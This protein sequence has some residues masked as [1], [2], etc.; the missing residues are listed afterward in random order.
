[1]ASEQRTDNEPSNQLLASR[2]QRRD[3]DRI[4]ADMVAQYSMNRLPVDVD[5]RR[6]VPMH[7]GI[8]RATHLL[9]P[10]PA[11]LLVNIPYFFLNCDAFCEGATSVADPFCGSGTV[12]LEGMI[13]GKLAYGTDANPLARLIA[14]AK[15]TPISE[16]SIRKALTF[17]RVSFPIQE[18]SVSITALD[19]NHWYAPHI[20]ADLSRLRRTVDELRPTSLRTFFLACL[21]VL[22]RK[23]SYAD[24]RLSVPVRLSVDRY[25]KGHPL[26]ESA[27][28]RVDW[29]KKASVLEEFELIVT[30]NAKRI[31][32]LSPFNRVASAQVIGEDAR[33]IDS[34]LMT[35]GAHNSKVDLI[36]SSPP[37][38]GAQKYIRASSL[39]LCWLGLCKDELRPLERKNIGRE[40]YAKSE[41][42][43]PL[44]CSVESAAGLLDRIRDINPLRAHI[45]TQYLNEMKMAIRSAHAALRAGGKFVLVIGNNT[46]CGM[47]FDTKRYIHELCKA[48]GF[49]TDFVLCDVIKSRGL[50]TKRNKTASIITVEWILVLRK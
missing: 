44:R 26:H 5:F 33:A 49:T 36:I 32:T 6:I 48:Q 24:P 37:Y 28:A 12:L 40:H 16:A 34:A 9:H 18:A 21:S 11:K 45:A 47:P 7:S 31:A 50:M 2:E 39:S 19:I 10:Y 15:V 38:V 8:D 27:Q 42:A 41:Y 20:V 23:L 17:V 29:V 46:I 13:S 35:A 25:K 4:Y 30:A 43:A 1:M 3:F 22:V 14:T